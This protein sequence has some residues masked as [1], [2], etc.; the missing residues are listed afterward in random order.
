MQEEPGWAGFTLHINHTL[1]VV[2]LSRNEVWMPWGCSLGKSYS[3]PVLPWRGCFHISVLLMKLAVKM[4]WW[5]PSRW[6]YITWDAAVNSLNM[7]MALGST[8]A[9]S[10]THTNSD[11][12]DGQ[13]KRPWKWRSGSLLCVGMKECQFQLIRV[14]G[15]NI[16]LCAE[17]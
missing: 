7:L 4:F 15:F 10:S 5:C 13:F 11:S 1:A 14:F 17:W 16:N 2:I 6:Q 12:R 8:E 9:V 3:I